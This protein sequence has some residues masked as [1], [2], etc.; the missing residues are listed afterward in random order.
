MNEIT[1]RVRRSTEKLRTAEAL[2]SLASMQNKNFAKQLIPARDKAWEAFGLYWEHDWTADAP[3]VSQK[4]RAEWQIKLQKQITGYTDSLFKVLIATLGAQI[5]KSSNTRF[6]V[7]NPLSWK[8]ND[9]A[10]L[11]YDGHYP[12]RVFD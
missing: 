7:F 11:E 12:V 5:K 2:A 9:V 6:Y 8:R 1:A 3:V 10:D 4:D